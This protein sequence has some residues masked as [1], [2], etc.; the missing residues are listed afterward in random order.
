MQ[1]RVT[2]ELA[3]IF[4]FLEF[5]NQCAQALLGAPMGLTD[6]LGPK[7]SAWHARL[8]QNS[9]FFTCGQDGVDHGFVERA[10]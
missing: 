9:G 7:P 5:K 10:L 8:F 6:A 4:L 3:F 1:R 2:S